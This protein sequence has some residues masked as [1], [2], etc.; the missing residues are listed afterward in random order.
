MEERSNETLMSENHEIEDRK[1]YDKLYSIDPLLWRTIRESRP[2]E[3]CSRCWVEFRPDQGYLF[4]YLGN[5]CIVDPEREVITVRV[6]GDGRESSFQEGLVILTYL[7]KACP[8]APS[9]RLVT[10]KDL[11]GGELFFR[12][13][14]SLFTR[15][16]IDRY[17]ADPGRFAVDAQKL[18]GV[19]VDYGDAAVRLRPLP[20]IPV[21]Y[22]LHRG[23]E[24][25]AA[26]MSVVFDDS[27]ESH[28]PLDV[29]WALVNV[30][31][32]QFARCSRES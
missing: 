20:K 3:V 4:S 6:G 15:P 8:S 10:E 30:T 21:T 23:D 32:L 1:G 27:I 9:G 24:E 2:M 11:K 5:D 25:F 12:G 28:L 7:A 19:A 14:H 16:L 17:A 26:S 13:P 31:T 18:G 22:I 29:V